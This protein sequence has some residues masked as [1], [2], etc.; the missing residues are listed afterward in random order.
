LESKYSITLKQV[1]QLIP[2]LKQHVLS[3]VFPSKILVLPKLPSTTVATINMNPHIAMI[4]I[5][6]GKNLVDDV[7]L[8]GGLIINMI[9]HSLKERLGF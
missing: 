1:F 5:C 3:K 9:T 6:V 2:N 8:D 4:P 7:L